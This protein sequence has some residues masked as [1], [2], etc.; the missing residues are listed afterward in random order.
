MGH[1]VH[2]GQRDSEDEV[3]A[4][5]KQ[6]GHHGLP[7]HLPQDVAVQQQVRA[8]RADDAE[9]SAARARPYRRAVVDA[10]VG[11][12]A[13]QIPEHARDQIDRHKSDAAENAFDHTSE[14][15]QAK[16]IGQ[17]V[18]KPD[19]KEHRHD[20]PPPLAVGDRRPEFGAESDQVL[21]VLRPA[22]GF[23]RDPHQHVYGE[24]HGRNRSCL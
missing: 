12:V 19:V 15:E 4:D 13:E 11:P 24:K 7:P 14:D 17:E 23:Q 10:D 5:D 1:V 3:D 22:S 9:Y 6:N 18:K 16:G 2:T 20:Q 8:E 21:T